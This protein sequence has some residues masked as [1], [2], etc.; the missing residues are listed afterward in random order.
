MATL[1]S[2]SLSLKIKYTSL[3]FGRDIYS[4]HLTSICQGVKL[5]VP[6][7]LTDT[8]MSIAVCLTKLQRFSLYEILV[9]WGHLWLSMSV[10]NLFECWTCLSLLKI[11]EPAIRALVCKVCP[12]TGRVFCTVLHTHCDQSTPLV[13]AINK[14]TKHN[15]VY[16]KSDPVWQG[17]WPT[18]LQLSGDIIFT[19]FA[20]FFLLYSTFYARYLKECKSILFL[21]T[22]VEHLWNIQPR[23]YYRKR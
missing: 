9:S 6:F 22:F 8:N 3:E 10:S 18:W 7:A 11:T 14:P 21:C 23:V 19:A 2:S 5:I 12:R 1:T 15:Y 13:L 17:Q 16:A 20:T 4:A